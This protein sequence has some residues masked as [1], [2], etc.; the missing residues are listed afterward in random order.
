MRLV[1]FA[2]RLAAGG[3]T[4]GAGGNVS[5]R[6]GN[7]IWVK[8]SGFAMEDLK[9]SC[10]AGLDLKTGRQARGKFR[11]TSEV[12]MHLEIYRRCPR[13][14]AVFHTHPPWLCGVISS[15]AEFKPMFPEVVAD[16]GGMIKLP[17]LLTGSP[18]LADAVAEAAKTHGTILMQ[19]HGLVCTGASM[20]QAYF[21]SCVAEDAAKSFVAACAVGKPRFLTDQE[22]AELERLE[23]G[24]YRE[25][26]AAREQ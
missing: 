6:D 15:D 18:E 13:V 19:N 5:C 25:E 1:A 21:R 16:L 20:K 24:P 11:A 8:P 2:R 22:I 7:M 14:K 23:A 9:A 12:P 17:Y 26:L 4:A 10:L 3:L